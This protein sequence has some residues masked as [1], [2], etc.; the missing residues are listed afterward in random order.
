MFHVSFQVTY[1]NQKP[2]YY[3]NRQF[4]I[5]CSEM[6]KRFVSNEYSQTLT[7]IHP[8]LPAALPA[9]SETRASQEQAFQPGHAHRQMDMQGV[10]QGGFH[11][12]NRFE[13][14]RMTHSEY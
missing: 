7:V 2:A 13:P 6:S 3:L 1:T 9:E 4:K 14:R 12:R 5:V 11:T 8:A 10:E